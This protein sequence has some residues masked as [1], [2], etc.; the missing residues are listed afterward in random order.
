[1]SEDFNI[2]ISVRNGRLL[3]AIRAHY[4]SVAALARKLPR[5][6]SRLNDLVT[7][8]VNPF[9]QNGWTDFALDVAA[10]VGKE[11]EDLWPEHLRELKLIKSTSEMEVDLESVKQLIQDGT[12]EKSLSQISAI[13]KFSEKLTKRERQC[14]AMRWALGHTL[15]ESAKVFGVTRER[16]RQIE[17]KAIR[18]M[19]GAALVA[20]YFTT[21]ARHGEY[22]PFLQKFEKNDNPRTT[23]KGI[24]LLSD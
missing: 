5:N 2:K 18:K 16:V 15:D 24:D 12:T 3:K 4:D 20:G 8:K 11:P 14:M 9:N 13:S 1:M 10:M 17:A 21:G 6:G 22:N 7:M 23:I 19:K